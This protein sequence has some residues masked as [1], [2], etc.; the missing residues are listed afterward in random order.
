MLLLFAGLY[1]FD[2]YD[3]SQERY[4]SWFFYPSFVDTPNLSLSWSSRFGME[5]EFSITYFSVFDELTT[6]FSSVLLYSGPIPVFPYLDE[7][8]TATWE[9]VMTFSD[10]ALLLIL[11]FSY[12]FTDR[13]R[14]GLNLKI[15]REGAFGYT[16]SGAGVDIGVGY[17]FIH[18][19]IR[20]IFKTRIVWGDH[21]DLIE[22]AYGIAISP[23][24]ILGENILSPSIFL[25]KKYEFSYLFSLDYIYH[26][27]FG[28]RF[29]IS[30]NGF[31][32]G[33]LI[34]LNSFSLS[35]LYSTLDAGGIHRIELRWKQGR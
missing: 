15:Y 33:G 27:I 29:S 2:F 20:D 26:R 17:R 10:L 4:P 6:G 3:V 35:Y 21:V 30:N 34:C 18:I 32:F 31:S 9:P 7:G 8:D 28:V 24:F 19:S 13:I 11:N 1:S 5:N 23:S 25:E 16:G 14:G 22:R 12:P